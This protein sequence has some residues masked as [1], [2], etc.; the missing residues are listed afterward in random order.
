MRQGTSLN[1]MA[2]RKLPDWTGEFDA[3][4]WAQ[5]FLKYVASH[6]E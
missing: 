4:S 3:N 1:R 2:G 5:F 6:M